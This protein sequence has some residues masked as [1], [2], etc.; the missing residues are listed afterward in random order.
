LQTEQLALV[1]GQSAMQDLTEEVLTDVRVHMKSIKVPTSF[2]KV[3]K[4]Q[5]VY[6]FDSPLSDSGLFVN[7]KS[8]Q[9]VGEPF[10]KIDQ[11]KTNCGLYVHFKHAKVP[12]KTEDKSE[13]K[14][15]AVRAALARY[16]RIA[17]HLQSCAI[18]SH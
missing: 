17:L 5:C 9:A 13:S 1:N 12:K 4:Q 2:D 15:E 3:Y 6:S 16:S 8:W 7:L 10:L 11:Q 18:H 14:E